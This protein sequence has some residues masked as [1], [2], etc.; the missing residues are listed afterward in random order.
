MK[1]A[2]IGRVIQC[3]PDQIQVSIDHR[4][5]FDLLSVQF[6]GRSR[7]H[8]PINSTVSDAASDTRPLAASA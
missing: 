5:E 1:E 2:L 6:R 7:L 8:L 3:A 4:R